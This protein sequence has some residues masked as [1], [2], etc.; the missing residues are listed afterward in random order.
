MRVHGKAITL[1]ALAIAVAGAS[2]ARAADEPVDETYEIERTIINEALNARCG[3]EIAIRVSVKGTLTEQEDGT[4][5]DNW[6]TE[7]TVTSPSATTRISATGTAEAEIENTGDGTVEL[8]LVEKQPALPVLLVGNDLIRLNGTDVTADVRFIF[9]YQGQ[10]IDTV[11]SLTVD[12]PESLA[13][14]GPGPG[15]YQVR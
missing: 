12:W 9:D 8:V 5:V 15:H 14:C 13:A 3:A 4:L 1:V 2:P 6:V 10:L 7:T 11:E